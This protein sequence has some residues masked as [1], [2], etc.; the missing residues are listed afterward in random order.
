[1]YRL[2]YVSNASRAMK[3]EDL[4]AI[5]EASRRRNRDLDVTGILLHLEH[6]TFM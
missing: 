5:L 6:R 1:M 4:I 3:D 2:I